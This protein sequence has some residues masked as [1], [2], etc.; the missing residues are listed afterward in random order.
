MILITMMTAAAT[1][2]TMMMMMLTTT[3][4]F[5]TSILLQRSDRGKET[6]TVSDSQVHPNRSSFNTHQQLQQQDCAELQVCQSGVPCPVNLPPCTKTRG[7]AFRKHDEKQGQFVELLYL[8][9]IS[10]PPS[11]DTDTLHPD[12]VMA[13]LPLTGGVRGL[14]KVN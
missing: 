2:T 12:P 8:S 5:I 6:P 13:S 3:T 7:S 11:S 10:F 9:Q 4:T 1:M 14:L